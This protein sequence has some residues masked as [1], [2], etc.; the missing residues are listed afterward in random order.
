MPYATGTKVKLAKDVQVTAN[1]TAVRI[2]LPGPLFLAEGLKG[3][4]A[5]STQDT[6]GVAQNAL[7]RFDEQL[8]GVQLQG[9]AADLVGNLR[10]QVVQYEAANTGPSTG[11]GTRTR[12]RVRFENGFVLDGIEEGW[13]TEA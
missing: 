7:A 10:Q 13:L 6:G 1:D 2:G 12:Y 5:G 11:G 9:F 8:R 3:V 4:V